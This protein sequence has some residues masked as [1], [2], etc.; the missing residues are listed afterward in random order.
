MEKLIHTNVAENVDRVLIQLELRRV[1][2]EEVYVKK[3]AQRDHVRLALI[4]Q[5]HRTHLF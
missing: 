4:P 1:V 3:A 5:Y 2:D